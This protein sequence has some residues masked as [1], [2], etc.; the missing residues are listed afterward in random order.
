MTSVVCVIGDAILDRYTFGRVDR[1]SPEAPVPVLRVGGTYDRP[2]GACNVAANVQ[3]LGVSAQLMSIVGQDEAGKD[4]MAAISSLLSRFH[5]QQERIETTVKTRIISGSHHL[6]RIDTEAAVK[7]TDLENILRYY[8]VYLEKCDYVIF[9]DYGK[10]FQQASK[11]IIKSAKSQGK[12]IAVDPKSADWSIY[13]GADLLTPN[14]QEYNQSCGDEKPS[15]VLKRLDIGAILITEGSGG[16]SYYS[17][18]K[19][20]IIRKP[21]QMFDVT[22]TCGAGDTAVA[23]FVVSQLENMSIEEGLDFA[24]IAAGVV[25][26]KMGTQVAVREEIDSLLRAT[27]KGEV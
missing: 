21:K 13:R 2:G 1:M 7:E 19:K 12:P 25:C 16:A 17:G 22:D 9:S 23:G 14:R 8:R 10:H 20:A 6:V 3:A 4:L 24:N 5:L 11:E 27:D 26:Q 18:N 15:S